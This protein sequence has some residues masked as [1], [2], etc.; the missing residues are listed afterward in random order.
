MEQS[1]QAI[2][3]ARRAGIDLDLMDSHLALTFEER[4]LRHAAALELVFALREA[5]AEYA[6]SAPATPEIR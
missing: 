1:K 4:A 3:D 5:G 2:E 6:Q